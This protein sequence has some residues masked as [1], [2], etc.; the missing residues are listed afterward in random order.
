LGTILGPAIGGWLSEPTTKYSGF[1][2]PSSLLA[3][4]P[5]LLPCLAVGIVIVICGF[6]MHVFLI[7][8]E[9]RATTPRSLQSTDHADP[10]N[11]KGSKG[12]KYARMKDSKIQLN[13]I[14]TNVN[15]N[16]DPDAH[17][18][19]DAG[20]KEKT[21]TSRL[22]ILFGDRLVALV[23]G[24]YSL[25]GFVDF[26][27]VEVLPLWATAPQHLGG[28]GFESSE[29][30]SLI[31]TIAA[32]VLALQLIVYPPLVHR[33]GAMFLY[34]AS[35]LITALSCLMLPFV[36]LWA[37]GSAQKPT[38]GVNAG[39]GAGTNAELR[40]QTPNP[41]VVWPL[42]FILRGIGEFFKQVMSPMFDDQ[43]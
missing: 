41:N 20:R 19:W 24:L 38:A 16:A 17:A 26:V 35:I 15:T 1:G 33:L 25:L 8:E 3:E 6:F 43:C 30:G 37:G 21:A 13:D 18:N 22:A 2:G 23:V 36:P 11:I 14:G 5:F 7:V 28:L 42:L 34:R 32:I 27:T 31:A 9:V 12:R 39:T 29:V 40:L 4:F 10:N